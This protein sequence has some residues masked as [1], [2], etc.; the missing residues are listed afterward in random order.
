MFRINRIKVLFRPQPVSFSVFFS[1]DMPS[2]DPLARLAPSRLDPSMSRSYNLSYVPNVKVPLPDPIGTPL[3]ASRKNTSPVS[4]QFD[5]IADEAAENRK[6]A[7]EM[8]DEVVKGN[9]NSLGKSQIT[10]LL[11]VL[12]T[13]K[14]ILPMIDISPREFE[15]VVDSQP[16]LAAEVLVQ[17][18]SSN[19]QKLHK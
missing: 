11:G 2:Q 5:K 15:L 14:E 12:G 7:F 17:S 19:S 13:D 9:G 1:S 18:H 16:D 4:V 6:F 8:M 3:S 10:K